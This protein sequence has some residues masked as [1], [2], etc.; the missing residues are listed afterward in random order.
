MEDMHT[1]LITFVIAYYG[2]W[3]DYFHLWAR[4]VENNPEI[5]VVIITDL[6]P[7]AN[8]PANIRLLTQTY[9]QVMERME[10]VIGW[11]LPRFR[12]HKLCDYK[13]LFPLAFPE[14]VEGAKYTGYCD[15]DLYFGDLNPLLT[16]AAEGDADIISPF[17]HVVGHCCLVR[18]DDKAKKIALQ[19]NRLKERLEEPNITFIDE[20]TL[21]ETAGKIGGFKVH[22]VD[23]LED[24]WSKQ[25]CFLG[26]T[27]VPGGYI[28]GLNSPCFLV[29]YTK[30]KVTV[31][32]AKARPHEVLYLH[33]MGMKQPRFWAGLTPC[34]YEDFTFTPYG[35]VSHL[36]PGTEVL[37][38]RFR[39]KVLL[40]QLPSR[41]Y[42]I[43]R[44][45]VPRGVLNLVIQ[46]R[47]F[48]RGRSR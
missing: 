46:F 25:K 23:S 37:T 35:I 39:L 38:W 9:E 33:F 22:I 30:G 29:Q 13:P 16:L 15:L 1:H 14:A 41:C 43:A 19:T 31:Y 18:N 28:S 6:Q 44:R 36:I 21:H 17:S 2:R 26:A 10:L 12:F 45:L 27:V 42:G 11:P 47:D 3:P 5:Q 20:G 4:S 24:E 32:D 48:V 34:L 40:C 8:L 7:P